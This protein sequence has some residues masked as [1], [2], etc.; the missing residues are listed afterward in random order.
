MWDTAGICSDMGKFLV[1][2]SLSWNQAGPGRSLACEYFSLRAIFEKYSSY[3]ETRVE[4]P[5]ANASGL[6]DGN[7]VYK[8][9]N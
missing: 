1:R 8:H 3:L 7:F 4:A 6:G 5:V 2:A 9:E